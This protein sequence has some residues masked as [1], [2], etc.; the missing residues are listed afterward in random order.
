MGA[1][2]KWYN[3]SGLNN[4]PIAQS[5]R[6]LPEHCA[7]SDGL[8]LSSVDLFFQKKDSNYGINVD[9]REIKNGYPGKKILAT[10]E[11]HLLSKEVAVSST[12]ET[13][14]RVIF[15]GPVFLKSGMQYALCV[16]PDAGS[17]DY[18]IWF[19]E[20]G[21]NDVV[22]G[23]PINTTW[24]DGVLYVSASDTWEPRLDADLKFR[25]YK[26]VFNAKKTGTVN[27]VNRDLE[28]FTITNQS[29]TFRNDEEVY[30]V[31]SAF[32]TGNVAITKS[33]QT[34]TGDGTTFTSDFAAGDT[35]VVRQTSDTNI[36][37][38][39]T[40]K[41]VES[42]TSLTLLGAPRVGITIGKAA[43]TPTG[44]VQRVFANATATQITLKDST[45]ET[46]LVFANND[47]IKGTISTAGC[48]IATVDNRTINYF[49]PMVYK[50]EPTGSTI[51]AT[52]KISDATNINNQTSTQLI[53]GVSNK[54]NDYEAAVFSR[55]NEIVGGDKKSLV[56]TQT[57]K[58]TNEN[59]SPV[60][61]PENS[62]LTTYQNFINN[63]NTNEKLFG[64]GQSHS[65][66][67]SKTVQ[68]ASGL[69]ADDLAVYVT[70]YRP[71]N[72]DIEAYCMVTA[73]DDSDKLID[74]Q[75]TKM[76][77]SPEQEQL[78]SSNDSANDFREFKF[79][80]PSIPT[81]DG[82][83][84]QAG[85]ANTTSGSTTV[86]IAS[87]STYYTA[88][89]LIVVTSGIKNNY[90]LGRVASATSSAVTLNTAADKTL[91]AALHY[92]VNADEKQSAVAYP[93]G[94]GTVKLR[95]FDSTGAE[96]ET[97]AYFQVKLVMLAESTHK[98]PRIADMRAIALSL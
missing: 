68:L 5:F 94:D 89:D 73:L 59:V 56:V 77:I 7:D 76:E 93:Q 79:S 81:I 83:N 10:S 39:L 75:F 85:T 40:V 33:T 36:S 51:T 42:D 67:L 72:T 14:T 11:K 44:R 29:G 52:Y 87:A 6:I 38:V 21:E 48:D 43:K 49:Q 55:S 17:P 86:A 57:L 74:K 16:H 30:K 90:V 24:G 97:F 80:I 25:M 66:Y 98:V 53:S 12:G 64:K 60:S 4:D 61:D 65:R 78:F 34:I 63:D 69:D 35:I 20:K 45:A 71:A 9:I 26:A 54:V 23:S 8:Y 84:K 95:Y 58:T 2:N 37:D 96:H 47:S 91:Q 41:S 92:K 62:L 22:S 46:G 70:G 27:L 82:T 31:P 15:P 19:A 28:F 3:K 88:G 13:P 32:A 1:T 18:R 50:T